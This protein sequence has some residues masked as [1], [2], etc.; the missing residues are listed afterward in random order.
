MNWSKALT[1][2]IEWD[3][4]ARKELRRLDFPI[5]KEILSYLRIRIAESDNP[6]V[7]GQSL[8]GNKVGLWRYRVGDYRI[9]C[10]IEDDTL[11][12][13]V[14]GVGHRKEIYEA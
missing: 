2:N 5:Q 14:V 7:F 6:R 10:R 4:R 1:W 12:V 13:F 3:D 9:I 8:S 11:V